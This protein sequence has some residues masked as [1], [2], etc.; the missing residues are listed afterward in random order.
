MIYDEYI[1][2]DKW[3]ELREKAKLRSN[4]KCEFCQEE[5]YAVHH[6][7]YP[8]EFKSDHINNLVVVCKRC[9]ALVHG[10]RKEDFE[11]FL[12]KL[13]ENGILMEKEMFDYF[14]KVIEIT[15]LWSRK[16]IDLFFDEVPRKLKHPKII[17]TREVK[18]HYVF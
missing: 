16:D 2:S 5:G 13:R 3:K 15:R 1:K 11:Y 8:K 7:F 9:H 14:H 4:N 17:F 18:E 10:I 12:C 6:V